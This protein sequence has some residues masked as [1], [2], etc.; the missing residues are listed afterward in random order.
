MFFDVGGPMDDHIKVVE[1]LFSAARFLEFRHHGIFLTSTNAC[2]EGV[3]RDKQAGGDRLICLPTEEVFA[4][5]R[6]GLPGDLR[7]RCSHAAPMRLVST[8]GSVEHV[9][10]QRVRPGRR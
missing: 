4:H 8:A 6:I 5:L 1:E 7:W 3:W 2:Y 9:E 10:R